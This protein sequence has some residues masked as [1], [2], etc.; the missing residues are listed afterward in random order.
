MMAFVEAP[1]RP[2]G[3]RETSVWFMV[4]YNR[5]TLNPKTISS[6]GAKCLDFVKLGI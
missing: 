1:K 2:G 4:G 5:H 6:R 3:I